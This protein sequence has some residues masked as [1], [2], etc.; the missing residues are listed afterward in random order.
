YRFPGMPMPMQQDFAMAQVYAIDVL[1]ERERDGRE[2]EIEFL[3]EELLVRQG[4]QV[5]INFDS[6]L[7]APNEKSDPLAPALRQ[8]TGMKL[9]YLLD[10]SGKVEQ[11]H[12][13]QQFV[14]KVTSTGRPESKGFFGS[15]YGEDYFKRL[16]DF[17]ASSVTR[18]GAPGDSWPSQNDVV[19]WVF[20]KLGLDL[21]NTLKV[22]PKM[23]A[24]VARCCN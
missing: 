17:A 16:V 5:F 3:A 14:E 22:G 6:K 23:M 19:I 8:M 15:I 11:V 1:G 21:E 24:A 12:D 2:V 10:A 9:K 13:F 7:E 20:G 4:K 18:T